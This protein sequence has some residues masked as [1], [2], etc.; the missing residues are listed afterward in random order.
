YIWQTWLLLKW[1]YPL[2]IGQPLRFRDVYRSFQMMVKK[3]IFTVRT[4]PLVKHSHY[5]FAL[6]NYLNRLEMLGL[7][8][9][10]GKSTFVKAKGMALPKTTNEALSIDEQVQQKFQT[11][12][13]Q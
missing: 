11:T 7:L 12:Y 2:S 4:L 10:I 5:S 6:M 1:V 8:Q 13:V 3:N 9:R